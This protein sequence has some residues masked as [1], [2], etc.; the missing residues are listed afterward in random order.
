MAD[1]VHVK[2]PDLTMATAEVGELI[3]HA[4]TKPATAVAP[5][6]TPASPV[7][8]AASSAAGAIHTK[9]TAMSA[10]L[11]PRGPAMQQAG[12]AATASLVAQ[13]AANSARLPSVPTPSFPSPSVPPAAT[14]PKVEALD[15][16]WKLDPPPKPPPD[17]RPGLPQPP[18]GWSNDPVLE[19]AQRIAYGHAWDKHKLEFPGMTQDQ[20]A[21]LIRSMLAGDPRTDPDLHVGQTPAG[22][23]AIYKNGVLVLYDPANTGDL[24]TVYRPKDGLDDFLR[25]VAP[26]PII[27]PPPDLP[28]VFE[29]PPTTQVPPTVLNHPPLPSGPTVF[30]HPPLP[31]WLQD[32]SPPGFQISP[33]QSPP[34]FGW[35][36]PDAPAPVGVGGGS[37][38]SGST[39]DDVERALKAA[40]KF[41]LGAVVVIGGILY[42]V[43]HLG[44]ALTLEPAPGS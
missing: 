34:I 7:D 13:D 29:H 17:P 12:S 25:K 40:G 31:P 14:K 35:D 16:H 26:V 3:E 1:A 9:M 18:G 4:S 27:S 23:T 39:L 15:Q 32:P 8:A 5:H 21:E 19:D 24:G 41:T 28:N 20:L 11:A 36:M 10:E 33:T 22:S 6:S 2:A 44:D 30:D 43:T 38:V 37:P 42:C